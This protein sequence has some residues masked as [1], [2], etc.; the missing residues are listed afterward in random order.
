M[1]QKK[2]PT[3]SKQP[4]QTRP[5]RRLKRPAYKSF[6]LSRRIKHHHANK[7]QPARKILLEALRIFRREWKLFGGITL[8]Y[9]LLTVLLVKGLQGGVNVKELTSMLREAGGGSQ[10]LISGLAIF[11]LLLGTS[12]SPSSDVAAVYQSILLIL[13]TLVIIWTL[14]HVIAGEKVKIKEAFYKG[15]YPVVP[16][17]LVLLVVGLQLVPLIA[18]NFLY[19]VV[20]GNGLAVTLLEQMLWGVL[21]ILLVIW[22]LY[23][24][25]SSLFA[26]YIVTLPDVTPVQALRSA[27]ELVRYRRLAVSRKLLFLPIVMLLIGTAIMLPVI[28]I[29]P[30]IAEWLFL[31]LSLAGLTLTHAYMYLLYRELL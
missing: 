11:G 25:T 31:L 20:F 29:I 26:L 18:A 6:R 15:P 10:N 24:V 27:R 8:I 28:L 19:G 3:A 7:L 22:S 30:A 13:V 5:Q 14:R 16:F 12:S 4:V 9:L 21:F 17:L 2:R 1:A 23:M